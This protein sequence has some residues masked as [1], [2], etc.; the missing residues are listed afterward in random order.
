MAEVHICPMAIAC[1][2]SRLAR[3]KHRQS[4]RQADD[5]AGQDD[6]RPDVRV[7]VAIGPGPS[8]RRNPDRGNNARHPLEQQQGREHSIGANEQPLLVL[9]E[10][11]VR[12]DDVRRDPRRPPRRTSGIDEIPLLLLGRGDDGAAEYRRLAISWRIA[13]GVG[14]DRTAT[15]VVASMSARKRNSAAEQQLALGRCR[16]RSAPTS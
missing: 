6:R 1:R 2:V 14:L 13:Q 7:N 5:D 9:V 4:N 3:L 11:N 12:H 15:G 10:Q 16:A 8:A